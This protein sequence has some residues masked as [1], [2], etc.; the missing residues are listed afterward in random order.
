MRW[1]LFVCRI[2]TQAR[3]KYSKLSIFTVAMQ[4][5]L[6]LGSGGVVPHPA[7]HM[8]TIASQPHHGHIPRLRAEWG[9]SLQ[10]GILHLG[11]WV[12]NTD[13]GQGMELGLRSSYLENSPL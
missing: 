4:R 12:G 5:P 2:L 1:A 10:M 9:L 13:I 8:T 11:A 6:R 3:V 7:C